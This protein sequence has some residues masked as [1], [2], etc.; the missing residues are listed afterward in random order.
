MPKM[1]IRLSNISNNRSKNCWIPPNRYLNDVDLFVA[2]F[3]AWSLGETEPSV[4][5]HMFYRVWGRQ[6]WGWHCQLMSWWIS[7]IP[8]VQSCLQPRPKWFSC[9]IKHLGKLSHWVQKAVG[10]GGAHYVL[11]DRAN[12]RRKVNNSHSPILS[13]VPRTPWAGN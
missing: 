3:H 5:E 11:V 9:F 4:P 7:L 6:R 2:G 10:D 8:I 12:C 13:L 1:G